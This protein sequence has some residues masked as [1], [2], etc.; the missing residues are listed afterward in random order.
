VLTRRDRV[1]AEHD[2]SARAYPRHLDA[3]R[4]TARR[5][6]VQTDLLTSAH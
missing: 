2:L 3:H 4:T 6:H 1:G 5:R